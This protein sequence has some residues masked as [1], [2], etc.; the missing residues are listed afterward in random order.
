MIYLKEFI[1][2][3]RKKHIFLLGLLIIVAAFLNNFPIKLIERIV[4]LAGGMNDNNISKILAFGMYYLAVQV[5]RAFITTYMNYVSDTLQQNIGV[6][7]QTKIYAKLLKSDLILIED[8]RTSNIT[9]TLVEDTEFVIQNLVTPITN[10]IFSILSFIFGLYFMITINK[11]LPFL[12]IP[13]GLITAFIS[14]N[15]QEKSTR[16]ANELRNSSQRLWKT[17]EEGINGILPIR[18][19]QYNNKYQRKVEKDVS[20]MKE[21]ILKQSKL[22]SLSYFSLSSLFMI[23]IG[24]IM[25]ISSVFV[26]K[27]YI[28]IG[29]LTAVMMYN[30]LLVDPLVDS[31]GLQQSLIKL[32]ISLKRIKNIM[33]IPID[34]MIGKE[35]IAVDSL[36]FTD[37][38]FGYGKECILSNINFEISSNCKLAIV[39]DTGSGKSTLAKLISGLYPISTGEVVYYYRNQRQEGVPKISYLIQDGYLFDTSIKNNIKIF[40]EKL[41][42]EEVEHL[43]ELCGLENLN[44]AYT[45]E[46]IGENGKHLSGGEKKRVELARTLANKDASIYIFDELTGSLDKNMAGVLLNNVLKELN[47]KLCVF[48]EHNLEFTKRMDLIV[49]MKKGRI[50]ELGTYEELMGEKGYYHM[51]MLSNTQ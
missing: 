8:E 39:G 27:G 1:D 28:S 10:L 2:R 37:V 35:R 44:K 9:N 50:V 19:F 20:M 4:D 48:I 40:N 30:H 46:T 14:K 43:I 23:T 25:I 24:S 29:G 11:I 49:V 12:I 33:D 51:L 47:N 13:L 38:S 7:I 36:K 6:N 5:A 34:P 15:I 32:R 26:I 16:N 41:S 42:E 3:D 45:D 17:F 31:L 21:V 18:V 22:N